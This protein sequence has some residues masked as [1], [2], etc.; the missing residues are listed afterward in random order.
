[1]CWGGGI[2]ATI[3]D[4]CPGSIAEI[5]LKCGYKHSSCN[6]LGCSG[7]LGL[8]YAIKNP[9]SSAE[10]WNFNARDD[11]AARQS[12]TSEYTASL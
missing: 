1:M 3:R 4:G 9:P 8:V 7:W 2:S 6:P 10:Y 11:C 5:G 12:F